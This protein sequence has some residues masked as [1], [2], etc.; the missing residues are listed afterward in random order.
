M[1]FGASCAFLYITIC[2]LNVKPTFL[3]CWTHVTSKMC[4]IW[5]VALT[6]SR[7]GMA[8][9]VM[10]K[11]KGV[12]LKTSTGRRRRRGKKDWRVSWNWHTLE[13]VSGR[14]CQKSTEIGFELDQSCWRSWRGNHKLQY[15]SLANGLIWREIKTLKL[16]ECVHF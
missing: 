9:M 13:R 14:R 11:D 1:G 3:L 4:T 15:S 6:Y 16:W 12:S 2:C 8:S 5:K 10:G 7:L